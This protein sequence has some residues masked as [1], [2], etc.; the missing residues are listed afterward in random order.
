M[1]K[2]IL[3]FVLVSVIVS[4][5]TTKPQIVTTKAAAKGSTTAEAP[6]RKTETLESTSKTTVYSEQVNEYVMQYKDIAQKNMKSHG[7]PASITLAQGILESGAGRGKL[8]V[9]ANNHFGIKCHT[10]WTGD[11]IYHDDDSAQECFRKYNEAEESFN[12]H[13]DFLT[14][15]SRY[16]ALFKLE[17]DDYE[18]WAKGLRAAGYATD[19][20]YPEKLI[21]LIQRFNLAQYDT[22]VLGGD[23]K[24][25]KDIPVPAPVPAVVT[26]PA[27]VPAVITTATPEPVAIITTTEPLTTPVEV[28]ETSTPTAATVSDSVVTTTTTTAPVAVTTTTSA[29]VVTPASAPVTVTTTTPA[30]A[31]TPAS[32]TVVT[33]TPAPAT[34]T[35]GVTTPAPGIAQGANAETPESYTVIKGDTLYSISKKNNTTVDALIQLNGLSGNAISIGQVLKLK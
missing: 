16:A 24:P 6:A 19:P 20:K 34:T 9:T 1:L 13:S 2:K 11:K 32:T 12:D 26:T 4:C 21:G 35:V 14:T 23:Y 33:T 30:V 7:V 5:S 25:V 31:T 3:A 10:E 27:P 15:R 8:A 29:A 22:Q 28:I 18:G 17:K